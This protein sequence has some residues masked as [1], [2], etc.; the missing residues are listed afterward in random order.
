MTKVIE[1]ELT[2]EQQQLKFELTN[3][4][5]QIKD[6]T[7]QKWA[8]EQQCTHTAPLLKKNRFNDY[9]SGSCVVCGIFLGWLCPDSPDRICHYF[10]CEQDGV[11]GVQLFEGKGFYPLPDLDED[12]DP[13]WETYD[14]C[15]FCHQ[16]EER[17]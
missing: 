17:K 12:Y 2:S 16:P 5:T 8:L 7:K 9:G 14:M 11:H 3:I 15:L 6:L 10:S 4:R 1:P 13:D